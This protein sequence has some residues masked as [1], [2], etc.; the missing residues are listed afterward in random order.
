MRV[1]IDESE[2]RVRLGA[3]RRTARQDGVAGWV[4]VLGEGSRQPAY[5]RGLP[6]VDP[7]PCLPSD[8]FEARLLGDDPAVWS[9]IYSL[10]ISDER[11]PQW[12]SA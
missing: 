4:R 7:M 11:N 10:D 2:Y 3:V 5:L 8:M 1:A 9:A 12:L 6:D